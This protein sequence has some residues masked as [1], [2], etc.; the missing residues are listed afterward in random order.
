MHK[1]RQSAT[2]ADFRNGMAVV[3]G[4]ILGVF[5]CLLISHAGYAVFIWLS[6]CSIISTATC[7]L[8]AVTWRFVIAHIP[9][10]ILLW[11]SLIFL[12]SDMRS[13]F[14]ISAFLLIPAL[15]STTTLMI[16]FSRMNPGAKM[17]SVT[18]LI[19]AFVIAWKLFVVP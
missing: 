2:S 18:A 17:T 8:C 15:T 10:I 4:V 12:L 7:Y 11:F 1:I 5:G 3:I 19:S 6:I 13:L 14:Q 9:T 16:L